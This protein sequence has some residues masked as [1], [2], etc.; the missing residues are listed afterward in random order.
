MK[1]H[2]VIVLGGGPGGSTLA[3]YLAARGVDVAL[4]EKEPFPRFHIGESLLPFSMDI[5]RETGVLDRLEDGRYIRKYGA[6]FVHHEGED[7]IYFDFAG[8]LDADHPTAFEVPRADFDRDLLENAVSRGAKVYQPERVTAVEAGPDRV[9][10][11]TDRETYLARYLADA[12]GRDAWLGKQNKM[13]FPNLDLNNFGVFTHFAGVERLENHPPGDITIAMLGGGRWGWIIPFAGDRASVG[14]VSS[15]V[16]FRESGDREAYLREAIATCAP[17]ARRLRDARRVT[18]LGAISNYSHY[19]ETLVGDRW[20]L[21]GD[22]ASFLDPIFSSGVHLAVSMAREASSMIG[23]ALEK[24]APLGAG[25]GPRYESFVRIG[26][27][28][29]HSF[30]RMFYDTPFVHSMRK[31]CGLKNLRMAFTS[32]VAGDVWNEHNPLFRKGLL[33]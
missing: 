5:F 3:S 25:L 21:V 28:R 11:R 31:T 13:R 32:V 33:G 18:D 6:Q 4:I 8:G 19:C 14:V 29:F 15:S 9:T 27:R 2:D 30:I 12:T 22:A 26:T 17:L 7:E 23:A 20:V 24:D 10:V 16:A 1:A